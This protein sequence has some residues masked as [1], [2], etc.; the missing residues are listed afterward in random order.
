MLFQELDHLPLGL[1]DTPAA[2]LHTLLDRPTLIHLPGRRAAP[3]FVTVLLHGN[4]DTGWEALRALL[5][6]YADRELPRALSLFIGNIEAAKEGLRVL[7]GQHDFN[8]IWNDGDEPEQQMT[9]ALVARMRERGVFASI[10]IHNNTGLNPH[11]ACI[12]RLDA[13][14]LHLANLFSRVIVYFTKPDGV[15]SLAMAPHCPAVTV[16][17]GKPGV[18]G[19]VEHARAFVEAVLHLDHF[20][21]HL[22]AAHDYELYHTV[23]RV[24]VPEEVSFGI[25]TPE[26]QLDFPAQLDHLNFRE[27]ESGTRLA[28]AAEGAYLHAWNEQ[29][30]DI[31]AEYFERWEGGLML[32]REVMPSML[33]L[34]ESII[35]QDCLCYLM[36]RLP[37]VE[38]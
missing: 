18:G 35:R 16:E 30:E 10:D 11:Y 23:V 4:E 6:D 38:G 22:P 26:R 15:Q 37:P 7:P 12:N 21:A 32:K 1:L 3:L 13:A 8:R 19:G 31:G 25:A 9:A 27:L 24:T 14:F 17:C 2:Q 28:M 36:E 34:N 33:T 20:P 5:R 29:G